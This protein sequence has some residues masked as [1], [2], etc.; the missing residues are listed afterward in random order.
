MSSFLDFTSDQIYAPGMS[1][2][3]PQLFHNVFTHP[4]KCYAFKNPRFGFCLYDQAAVVIQNFLRGETELSATMF[5][6]PERFRT[7]NGDAVLYDVL[8]IDSI[9]V[10]EFGDLLFKE[11][12]WADLRSR[13][14]PLR[15]R[16][17]A[18]LDTT[19]PHFGALGDAQLINRINRWELKRHRTI[20]ERRH[21]LLD[22][23]AE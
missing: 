4:W 10:N 21:R 9:W 13:L 14:E 23:L 6:E 20:Q 18:F 5:A 17:V 22:I 2:V 7:E 3:G 16:R 11:I 12:N 8:V 19:Y 1:C 15:D